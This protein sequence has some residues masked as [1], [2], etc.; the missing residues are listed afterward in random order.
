MNESLRLLKPA[1]VLIKKAKSERASVVAQAYRVKKA[2]TRV[3]LAKKDYAPDF[4]VGVMY[5][6]RGGD[7]ADF[8]S[9][10]L[11]ANFPFYSNEK[12]DNAVDQLKAERM[13]TVYRLSDKRN[14]VAQQVQ[15]AMIDY[16]LKMT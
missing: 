11:S 1:N 9:I 5:G 10:K 3:A 14:H 16:P 7:R 4:N 12:R 15:Q 8:G 2:E 13:S 6:L